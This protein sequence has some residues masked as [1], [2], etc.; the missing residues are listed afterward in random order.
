MHTKGPWKV[1]KVK[2]RL[3]GENNTSVIYNFPPQVG[4]TDN[5]QEQEANAEFI[6]RACNSHYDLLEACEMML[7]LIEG[8]NLDEKFDG[9]TEVLRDAIAKAEGGK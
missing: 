2:N 4:P 7:R 6:V 1:D 3:Y 9:E 8:E 5:D